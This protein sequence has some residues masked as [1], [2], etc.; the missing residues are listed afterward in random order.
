MEDAKTLV[1]QAVRA[2]YS[3]EQVVIIDVL[4]YHDILSMTQ[5]RSWSITHDQKSLRKACA[6]LERAKLVCTRQLHEDESYIFLDYYQAVHAIQYMV[7]ELRRQ[8]LD[9]NK[10]VSTTEIVRHYTC[11]RCTTKWP[12]I[13]VIDNAD[14]DA[15]FLCKRCVTPSI[16]CEEPVRPDP[17]PRF[18]KQFAPFIHVLER[19]DSKSVPRAVF[20]D[21]YAQNYPEGGG[22]TY[23]RRCS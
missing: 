3:P 2:F 16:L 5:L 8:V 12:L 19:L 6:E 1:K 10:Q 4:S 9:E 14:R 17:L 23:K 21:L 22:D 20:E 7:H 15:G 13:D 18:H 11:P